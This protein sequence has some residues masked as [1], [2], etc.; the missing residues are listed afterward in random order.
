MYQ[1]GGSLYHGF[2]FDYGPLLFLPAVWLAT[3]LNLPLGDGYYLF[4][5]TGLLHE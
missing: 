1:R 4:W 3:L 2:E 5:T